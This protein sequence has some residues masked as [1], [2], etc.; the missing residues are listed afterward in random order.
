[1]SG[2]SKTLN[3]W[4]KSW[5]LDSSPS[6]DEN[7][8]SVL[9]NWAQDGA[10]EYLELILEAHVFLWIQSNFNNTRNVV[11]MLDRAPCYTPNVVR[12]HLNFWPKRRLATQLPGPQSPGLF[13]MGKCQS[14][15]QRQ[16]VSQHQ[17]PQGLHQQGLGR[18]VRGKRSSTSAPGSGPGLR[19]SS[20]PRQDI[21]IAGKL[22]LKPTK[23]PNLG[24]TL[25]KLANLWQF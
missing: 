16:V 11:L 24:S 3:I 17:G 5:Y 18:H 21:L 2:W 8:P 7:G 14:D 20:R 13:D 6:R 23:P 22:Q 1:M 12:A 10:K 19:L 15:V 25:W 4:P 9:T